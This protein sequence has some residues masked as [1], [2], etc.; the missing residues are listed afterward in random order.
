MIFS[1]LGVSTIV[2]TSDVSAGVSTS[3]VSVIFS[4]SGVSTSDVSA[5]VSVIFSTSGVYTVAFTFGSFAFLVVVF[6]VFFSASSGSIT[7]A[8]PRAK[9]TSSSG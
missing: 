7:P 8:S 2:S 5:G 3:G 9:I 4:T 1:T 6:L